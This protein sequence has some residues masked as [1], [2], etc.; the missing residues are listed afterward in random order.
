M[1]RSFSM[2]SFVTA[3]VACGLLAA[4]PTTAAA[5]VRGAA[6]KSLGQDYH[7][8]TG[9]STTRHAMD[10]AAILNYYGAA[11]QPVPAAVTQSHAK[12]IRSN[13]EHSQKAYA[14]L[15]PAAKSPSAQEQLA[16]IEKHH[17]AALEQLEKLDAHGEKDEASHADIT[18]AS[19][20]IHK[21]LAAADEAA[22]KLQKELKLEKL[23]APAGK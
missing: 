15:K 13:V 5:Q 3:I 9:S 19:A 2:K 6:S 4:L 11:E 7:F 23:P 20:A 1:T 21:E 12:A 14:A 22:A 16:T 8:Y 10:H 18:A 17:K